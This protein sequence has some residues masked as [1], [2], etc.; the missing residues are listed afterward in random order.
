LSK[1]TFS[2]ENWFYKE[3]VS[4]TEAAVEQHTNV[5]PSDQHRAFPT[6][7][8]QKKRKP[9]LSPD[10][11]FSP[12]DCFTPGWK[13]ESLLSKNVIKFNRLIALVQLDIKSELFKG[14]DFPRS[15]KISIHSEFLSYAEALSLHLEGYDDL[16]KF[17]SLLQPDTINDHK[18]L[19]DFI[20]IYT[21]RVATITFLKLRFISAL[22]DQC[23]LELT[24]RA[25]LYPTS[26]LLQIFKKGSVS[27]LNSR[28]LESNQYSWYRPHEGMKETMKELLLVS[29]E[30]TITEITKHV[31]LKTQIRSD[32]ARSYS[33]ALSHVSFGLFLNSIQINFPKWLESHGGEKFCYL[34]QKHEEII[35]CKYFGDYLESLSLSHWL[36][37][38]NN[39]D[40]RWNE[41]LCPDFKGIEFISGI[42][43]K[44]CNE[45]QFLYFLAQKSHHQNER[46]I[47]YICR[48]MREHFRN[49]KNQYPRTTLLLE[50]NPFYTSTYDRV[51]LN[52]CQFPKNNPQHY[53]MNQILGQVK[54]LKSDGYLFVLSSKKLFV[55]SL[56]ERLE[57]LL[58]ELAVEAIFDLEHIKG[59]GEVGSY[60]YVFRKKG[61]DSE[62]K[63][64][65]SYFRISAELDSFH[66][67][68]SITEHL[69]KFYLSHINESPSMAHL[70][71]E[72]SFRIEYFQEA[73]VNG[74]L[75]HSTNDDSTR[76][77]HPT[78]FKNLL[79]NSVPLESLFEIRA[80]NPN[81][82][83]S[84]KESFLNLG[85]RKDLSY[86][87]VVD[88]RQMDV[89]LELHPMDTLQS[90][91]SDYGQALCA[92]FQLLPKVQGLN[93]NILRHFFKSVVGKQMANMAFSGRFS[94]IK[95][96]LSKFLIPKF[97]TETETLPAQ[98]QSAYGLFSFSEEKFL[99]LDPDELM[100]NFKHIDIISRELFPKFA[101][102]ILSRYT[103]LEKTLSHLVWKMDESKA[104]STFSFNNPILQGLLVQKP[105]SPIYPRHSDVFIEFVDG[106]SPQD[107]HKTLSHTQVKVIQKNDLKLHH[108]ELY[109]NQEAIVRIHS[110]EHMIMFLQFILSHAVKLPIAKVLRAT[111]APNLADLKEVIEMSQNFKTNY[112]KLLVMIQ[113]TISDAFTHNLINKRNV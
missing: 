29:K 36:A 104:G 77:T 37:Q 52:L 63:P 31:S 1:K 16:G 88:K 66:H 84:I 64:F 95:G 32:Q 89:N 53:L 23:S 113:Q 25:L 68:S 110:D 107:I 69:R 59:R 54:F 61:A 10:L 62:P 9:L 55:P 86:F 27:E 58:K 4:K 22:I 41:I 3:S 80:L 92:Y 34:D 91:Y 33:H 6:F 12:L 51:V 28:A 99:E 105:N 2:A 76:I 30:L 82:L 72:D 8:Y 97:F 87:L 21:N 48:V 20:N 38:E 85:L 24:D 43:V 109:S 108:L 13:G 49:R 94:M 78:F 71:C 17:W 26:F 67:F 46:P 5:S 81:D 111:Y 35:S 93:P 101:C 100:K 70:D 83:T 39:I 74:M 112:S 102:D 44:I 73:I 47:D 45:L 96:S 56:S 57:P 15:I 79:N 18:E 19:S 90:I 42:F 106:T 103:Q 65:F 14:R 40:F 60:I 50:D 7:S 98:Y 75:I 11:K